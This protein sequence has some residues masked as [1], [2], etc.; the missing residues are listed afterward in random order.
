MTAHSDRLG[1]I[2]VPIL[3]ASGTF[4]HARS[5][6][7]VELSC[8]GGSSRKPS[9]RPHRQSTATRRRNRRRGMLNSIG[10]D[11]DGS[12]T[13]D[14]HLPFLVPVRVPD[15]ANVRQERR[16]VRLLAERTG[17]APECA[18]NNFPAR[19]LAAR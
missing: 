11:N 6:P 19:T 8:L 3:V 4:G 16:R 1:G 7:S 15:H 12:I 14:H 5:G 18:L 9:R 10:F 13:F 17:R 2:A